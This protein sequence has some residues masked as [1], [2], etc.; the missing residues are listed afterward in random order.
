MVKKYLKYFYLIVILTSITQYTNAQDVQFSQFYAAPTYLNPAFAG[1]IAG[2]RIASIFRTQY[3][4]F[5]GNYKS[6]NVSVDHNFIDQNSGLGLNITKDQAG[7]VD[8]NFTKI[9]L[10]YSYMLNI[11]RKVHARFGLGLAYARRSI[12]QSKFIFSSQINNSSGSSISNTYVFEN[13]SYLDFS[14]GAII[15][16]KN[17]WSGLAFKHL[18]RPQQNITVNSSLVNPLPILSSFHSGYTF[19]LKK[20]I[21]NKALLSMTPVVHYK[22]SEKWDQLDLGTYFNKGILTFGV[23]YRGLPML[24][25]NP[26]RDL[27]ELN[28][29]NP[30]NQDA[31]VLLFGTEVN[32]FR[33][34]YSY[35]ITVSRLSGSSGGSHEI[36]LIWEISSR[37]QKLSYRRHSVPCAKF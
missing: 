30:I 35:D 27:N 33:L 24:K 21:K 36:S 5:S 29:G 2:T 12:D 10:A 26:D 13:S 22:F 23:W 18:N 8:L 1:N 3:T 15:Y 11:N 34:A 14:S 19:A 17:W 16:G 37:Q 7:T 25:N 32:D 28:P 31:V 6:Y 9:D 20:N 4:A